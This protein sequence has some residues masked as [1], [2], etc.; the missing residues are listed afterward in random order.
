MIR[1]PPRSTLFPYTTLF[2]S[3]GH[4]ETYRENMYSPMSIEEVDYYLKPMNCP[5]HIMIYKNRV[6]SYRDLPIRLAEL[7][8]VYRYERSGTLHGMLRVRGFTQDDSHIFCTPDQVVDEVA[9]VID[10]AMHMARVFGYEFQAY[11]ATR[12]EKAIGSEEV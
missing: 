8:T 10:L 2:R 3:S 4:L 5:G 11:L 7:G 1:R 6:H 9:S 12:P